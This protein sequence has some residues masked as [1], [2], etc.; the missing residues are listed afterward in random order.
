MT[1]GSVLSDTI[2]EEQAYSK[3]A[4][5]RDARDN[6]GNGGVAEVEA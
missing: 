4:G 3:V 6:G 1:L 2:K 5:T